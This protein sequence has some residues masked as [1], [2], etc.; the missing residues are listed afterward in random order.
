MKL[1]TTSAIVLSALLA[2]TQAMAAEPDYTLTYNV[3]ATTDY[4][5][6]SIAQTSFKPAVQAGADFAHKSGVTADLGSTRR[7]ERRLAEGGVRR[8]INSSGRSRPRCTTCRR[9]VLRYWHA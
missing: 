3:G 7:L 9:V 8:R 1:T 5:F 2:T 6:R 4:R